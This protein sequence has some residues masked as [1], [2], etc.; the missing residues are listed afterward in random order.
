MH[1]V[2]IVYSGVEDVL[3]NGGYSDLDLE[4]CMHCLY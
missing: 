1:A 2:Y 3:T 4:L